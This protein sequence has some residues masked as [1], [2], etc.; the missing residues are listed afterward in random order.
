MI[1]K[2]RIIAIREFGPR[3]ESSKIRVGVATLAVVAVVIPIILGHAYGQPSQK[4]PKPAFDV[5]SIHEWGPGHGPPDPITPGV[6]F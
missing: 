2:E 3:R 1:F 6:Q 4:S 5:A